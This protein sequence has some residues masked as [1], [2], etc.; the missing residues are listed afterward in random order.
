MRR[1]QLS[2]P[3]FIVRTTYILII[4]TL[5][6]TSCAKQTR[7]LAKTDI[8]ARPVETIPAEDSVSPDTIRVSTIEIDT[9]DTVREESLIPTVEQADTTIDLS[10]GTGQTVA[11]SESEDEPVAVESMETP[12]ETVTA[13]LDQRDVTPEMSSEILFP[14]DVIEPYMIK[15]DDYLVK[16][17]R[18]E[19]GDP[20]KWRDI[21]EWNRDE[22]GDNPNLI[23]PFHFLNLMKPADVAKTCKLSFFTREINKGETLWSIAREVYGN[24]LAWIVLYW[25]N[26]ELV[27]AHEGILV[28]GSTLRV[29]DQIDPCLASD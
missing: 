19:Y 13:M 7:N 21:Y 11:E 16:I 12:D 3:E 23:Y 26:E 17:A 9:I 8:P 22:I 10:A 15:P 20:R 1:P 18:N 6:V 27:N 14:E 2:Q 28:P 24:E 29:R 5:L 4:L 25:D